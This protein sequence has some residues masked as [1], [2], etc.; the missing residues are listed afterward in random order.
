[1]IDIHCHILP[2]IDDGAES[3]EDALEMARLAVYSGVTE[4][5]ATPHFRGD[6]D[7]LEQ[8]K[9]I[10]QRY[11]EMVHALERW[12]VPLKLHKGAEIL[13]TPHTPDMAAAGTLPTIGNTRYV[14][15]EF[16]FNESFS[17]MDDTL[18]AIAD[19]G[20]R[21]IIAHPERYRTIQHTPHRAQ[22]WVE[23]GFVLQLNKGS[24]LGTFGNRAESTANELLE[25]GLAHLIASDGH[26]CQSRTPHIGA[27]LE[28]AEEFCEPD[29][30]K[31]LLEDIPAQILRGESIEGLFDAD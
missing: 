20:Y 5:V 29:Y 26:G 4:M 22:D 24:L 1:M 10:D 8:L 27:L 25:L 9:L 23:H 19:Y 6:P 11:Q 3:L 17:F 15:T 14:L 31:L 2:N 16:Y 28:W 12:R 7:G 30:T 18:C 21:P 13:C